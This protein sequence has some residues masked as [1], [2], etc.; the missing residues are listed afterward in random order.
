MCRQREP[1]TVPEI[2]VDEHGDPRAAENDVW[3]ARQTRVM[4]NCP[5]APLFH[6]EPAAIFCE[7]EGVVH[8]TCDLR[9]EASVPRGRVRALSRAPKA[10]RLQRGL[11][12]CRLAAP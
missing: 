11:G 8:E 10:R 3:T 6:N 2:S 1:P 4:N 5:V 12:R 7:G 9:G